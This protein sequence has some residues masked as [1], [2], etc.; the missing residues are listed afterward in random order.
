MTF[1]AFDRKGKK[2][3]DRAKQNV[4]NENRRW[5][6]QK[7]IK[8]HRQTCLN[9]LS[10]ISVETEPQN[11]SDLNGCYLWRFSRLWD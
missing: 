6:G 8:N 11:G 10:F 3:T 1:K 2:K 7:S 9:Q 4:L 5:N